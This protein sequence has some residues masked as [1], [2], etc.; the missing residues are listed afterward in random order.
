M[1]LDLALVS[2]QPDFSVLVEPVTRAVVDD[3]EDLAWSEARDEL[4]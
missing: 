3:E 2:R 4:L 1:K